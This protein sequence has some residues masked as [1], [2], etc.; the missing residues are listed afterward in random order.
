MLSEVIV[1]AKTNEVKP[2][3]SYEQASTFVIG[4]PRKE[5]FRDQ[6]TL[7][8]PRAK[9]LEIPHRGSATGPGPLFCFSLWYCWSG[10]ARPK[11]VQIKEFVSSAVGLKQCLDTVFSRE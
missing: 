7:P 5:T 8:A 11:S 1:P 2:Q 4:V 6:E 10:P 3:E 9:G